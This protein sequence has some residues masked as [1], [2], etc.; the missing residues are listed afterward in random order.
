MD[1]GAL[2]RGA[3]IAP[4]QVNVQADVSPSSTYVLVSSGLGVGIWVGT[5]APGMTAT[6]GSIAIRTDASTNT[7]RLYVNTTG[8]T[9]WTGVNTVG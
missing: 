1:R 9:T 8:S 3:V 6:Q 4:S 5:G 7:T 2:I